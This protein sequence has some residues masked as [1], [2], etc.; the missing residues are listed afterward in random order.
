M[1][2]RGNLITETVVHAF[3]HSAAIEKLFGNPY[4][5]CHNLAEQLL[6]SGF[7]GRCY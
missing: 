3:F 6:I 7:L 5:L 1:V 2:F 4:F